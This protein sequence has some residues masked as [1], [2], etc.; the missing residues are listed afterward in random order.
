MSLNPVYLI[1]CP[2]DEQNG[3]A[4]LA[5]MVIAA[6]LPL[7]CFVVEDQKSAI[8]FLKKIDSGFPVPECVFLLL[9]E[10]TRRSEIAGLLQ[11]TAGQAVGVISQ[12]GCPCVAD[13]GADF[14]SGARRQGRPIYPL[15]GPS[16]ILLALMGSGLNGQ[17][18]AFNGYLPKEKNER[19]K[20][21]KFL[22]RRSASEGQTQIFMET[23]YRNAALLR[24]ALTV[25][26]PETRLCVAV[27]LT[28]A[29]QSIQTMTVREWRKTTVVLDKRPAIFLLNA[30]AEK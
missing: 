8:R 10:H 17:N 27:D 21:I 4:A 19:E 1:P 14:V 29:S 24:E 30:A 26:G 7:R 3:F 18:F 15:V 12:A 23:P 6:V 2:I 16:A 13:P 9:N 22:E 28:A 11:Q 5:P 20:K 25:C